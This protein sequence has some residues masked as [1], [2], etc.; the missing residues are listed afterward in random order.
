MV[1]VLI[2]VLILT[3]SYY[4]IGKTGREFYISIA[5]LTFVK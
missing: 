5:C 3:M 2:K 1:R 4:E